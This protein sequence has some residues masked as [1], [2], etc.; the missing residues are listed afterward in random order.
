M[1]NTCVRRQKHR[2]FIFPIR[3]LKKRSHIIGREGSEEAN[4]VAEEFLGRVRENGYIKGRSIEREGGAS[5][6]RLGLLRHVRD[7]KR[8]TARGLR[9]AFGGAWPPHGSRVRPMLRSLVVNA[10]LCCIS[11]SIEMFQFLTD[12]RSTSYIIFAHRPRAAVT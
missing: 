8:I 4:K 6:T 10:R 12:H 7:G 3:L 5:G 2:L 1:K 9:S 11:S